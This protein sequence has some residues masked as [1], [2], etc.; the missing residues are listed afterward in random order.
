LIFQVAAL[1]F[2]ILG[3]INAAKGEMKKLPII[4]GIEIIK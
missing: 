2:L 3:I 4:G 1:V